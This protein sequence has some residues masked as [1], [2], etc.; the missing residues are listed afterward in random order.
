MY[1][2]RRLRLCKYLLERGFHYVE[3]KPDIKNPKFNVW[4]F[5]ISPELLIEVEN[6][7]H[8]KEFLERI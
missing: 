7:Y 6:Y 2:C 5:K 1:V 8:R 4:I 3:E